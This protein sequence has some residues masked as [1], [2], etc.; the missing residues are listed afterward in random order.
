MVSSFNSGFVTDG[1]AFLLGN[2]QLR[3]VRIQPRVSPQEQERPSH[4]DQEDTEN[5]GAHWGPLDTNTT[6]PDSI[7]HYRSQETMDKLAASWDSGSG[8]MV[9]LGRNISTALQ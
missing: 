3:Q 7:W 8:Y 6:D 9:K 5:Y 2:V 4:P 1:N